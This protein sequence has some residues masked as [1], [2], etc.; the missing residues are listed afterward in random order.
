VGKV[1]ITRRIMVSIPDSLLREM[2]IVVAENKSN[3]SELVRDAMCYYLRAQKHSQLR[4][5]MKRGYL[6]M[7]QMNLSLSEENLAL[8]NEAMSRLTDRKA[9][10]V[11]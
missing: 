5:A 2:D 4:E 8:E 1:V 3:R 9:S 11:S 6:E 10:G 7:A